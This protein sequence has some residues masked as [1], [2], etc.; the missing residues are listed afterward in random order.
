[1][2]SF[3][4]INK[5]FYSG[6][7]DIEIYLLIFFSFSIF[8]RIKILPIT[9]YLTISGHQKIRFILS[10][11]LFFIGLF[12]GLYF[13]SKYSIYGTILLYLFIN[14]MAY[15]MYKIYIKRLLDNSFQFKFEVSIIIYAIFLSFIQF[16]NYFDIIYNFIIYMFLSLALL[17]NLYNSKHF[18]KFN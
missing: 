15:L 6:V 10:I 2:F 16:S 13:I 9:T 8:L 1:M 5:Y 4:I 17:Y 12:F 11:I 18:E 14:F 3:P 7:F